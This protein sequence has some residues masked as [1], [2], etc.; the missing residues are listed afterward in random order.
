LTAI[1]EL[2]ARHILV[3]I[4]TI[5]M[6]GIND[7]HIVEVAKT[8]AN[9]GADIF[10]A[11]PLYRNLESAFAHIPTPSKALVAQIRHET[12][13]YL[14]QMHHCTRCRADAV[15]LLGDGINSTLQEAMR[16]CA[17]LPD[18]EPSRKTQNRP[19]IAV[20]SME[21]VLVNQH[22]GEAT[23]LFIFDDKLRLID[24]RK[25]PK[26]GNGKARWESLAQILSDCSTLLVN[27]IGNNPKVILEEQGIKTFVIEGIIEEALNH[28]NQGIS[29]NHLTKRT[30]KACQSS[31]T[32]SATGCE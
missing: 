22:L 26:A 23:E 12:A 3:K 28:L 9:L 30:Q 32:G 6:P 21:G 20:A 11:I 5:I 29:I 4:N 19:Y 25:T 31:C 14:P 17:Q 2:K 8:V 1:R 16:T 7:R 13:N 18:F 24:Q 10:N 27:G 15:G